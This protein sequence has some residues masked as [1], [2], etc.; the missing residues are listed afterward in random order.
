[1]LR[2]LKSFRDFFKI[3]ISFISSIIPDFLHIFKI[4][5]I[6]KN[7]LFLLSL[8]IFLSPYFRSSAVWVTTIILQSFFIL[9]VNKYLDFEKNTNQNLLLYYLLINCGVHKTIL[10]YFFFF[11][12]LK[13]LEILKF[14][15]YLI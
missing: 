9:S 7:I 13:F 2:L 5:G 8:I 6:N 12:F 14:K 11:Y 1:M 15:K 10:Y 4:L 3:F